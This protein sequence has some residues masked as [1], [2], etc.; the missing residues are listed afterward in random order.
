ME[1]MPWTW[2]WHKDP[3]SWVS[4]G[5]GSHAQ[6]LIC[7]GLKPILCLSSSALTDH[8]LGAFLM[9]LHSSRDPGCSTIL[10]FSTCSLSEIIGLGS[11]ASVLLLARVYVPFPSTFMF[12][13]SIITWLGQ[14][15]N[16]YAQVSCK[17]LLHTHVNTRAHLH[18]HIPER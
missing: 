1:R 11:L 8:P 17:V 5:Q 9:S 4:K 7:F 10:Q 16:L 13:L 12:S 2:E 14:F 6:W 15:Q 3:C 18:I